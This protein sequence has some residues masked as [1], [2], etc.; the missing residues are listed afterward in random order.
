M[1]AFVS[2][3]KQGED[4]DFAYRRHH[5]LMRP[6]FPHPE[7]YKKFFRTWGLDVKE[8]ES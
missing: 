2:G 7:F 5:M 6:D 1:A 3:L 4:K 8:D